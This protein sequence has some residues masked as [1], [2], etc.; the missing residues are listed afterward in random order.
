MALYTCVDTGNKSVTGF[1]Q[2]LR[3]VQPPNS[4]ENLINS[5]IV[6]H[7]EKTRQSVTPRSPVQILD[8]RVK[9]I[10]AERPL[11]ARP[12]E[13]GHKWLKSN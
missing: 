10:G 5:M 6:H 8:E 7:P 9:P 3:P 1:W 2:P 13:S 11:P 4:S 12:L